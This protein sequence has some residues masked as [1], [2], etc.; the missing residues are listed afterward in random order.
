[1][2]DATRRIGRYRVVRVLGAG[3]FATV[4]EAVDE[5][6]DDRVAIKVL[7]ENHSLDADIRERFL[8]EGRLLR[9]ID[10]ADVVRVLD[11]GETD[12]LQPYL[13][14]ELADRGTLADR[15]TSLRNDGWQPGPDDVRALVGPMARALAA[16]HR[17]DVVHRDLSPGN[18]LLRS[19]LA[20]DPT[21]PPTPLVARDERLVLA[22]L[23]LGKDLARSS[24]LTVAGGTE[25]FRPPEQRGEA[26]RVDGR[27]DLWSL[28]SLVVWLAAG[29]HPTDQRHGR[30]LLE[31]TWLPSQV[32]EPVVRSLASMPD[33]RHDTVGAWERDVLGALQIAAPS[34]VWPPPGAAASAFPAP[35]AS[36]EAEV[37]S[38][39]AQG[40]IG[41][42]RAWP[43]MAG[44]A[45][46]MLILG[47]ALGAAV[48]SWEPGSPRQVVSTTEDGWT[49]VRQE[50]GE[51][52][53]LLEGPAVIEV[54]GTARFEVEVAGAQGWVWIA[55]DGQLYPETARLEVATRSAGLARVTV[56]ATSSAG[57]ELRAELTVSVVER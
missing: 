34:S 41:R 10:S 37:T 29:E 6:L 43:R 11:L 5:P 26:G 55:P 38:T 45:A 27:A 17:A 50:A 13:V 28:S 54:G 32:V 57:E 33:D 4:L 36:A 30:E 14:L 40:K 51:V 16:V 25:G 47:V 22:D 23:G 2:S 18:V 31:R 15:V 35:D 39:R 46:I 19:T 53:I 9:R 44:L 24:G 48:A 20:P 42:Q 56:V 49:T 8:A 12:R 7:A 1:M 52:T 3:G 21:R